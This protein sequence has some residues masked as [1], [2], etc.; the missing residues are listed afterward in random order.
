MAAGMTMEQILADYPELGL[1]DFPA[2][3]DYA[4][5]VGRRVAL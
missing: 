1:A 4:A 5:R 3:F 2:I